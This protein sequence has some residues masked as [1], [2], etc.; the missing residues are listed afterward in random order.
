M[1]FDG[2][3]RSTRR[4]SFR[5]P[6]I[7]S[8]WRAE[9]LRPI[10]RG[11]LADLLSADGDRERPH[12]DLA[13]VDLRA[14]GSDVDMH[15]IQLPSREEKVLAPLSSLEADDV[16]AQHAAQ[17]R[18]PHLVGQG[19]EVG[20][21][22]ERCVGEVEDPRLRD[23]LSQHA[24]N[25]R[26]VVILDQED[27]IVLRLCRERPSER[28]V[29]F[30]IVGPFGLGLFAESRG[31]RD[32]PQVVVDEPQD[33]IGDAVVIGVVLL[34]G[35]I[36][37]SDPLGRPLE[38]A[39]PG[40]DLSITLRDGGGDPG[41]VVSLEYPS[42]HRDQASRP[43]VGDEFAVLPSLEG[44]WTSVRCHDEGGFHRGV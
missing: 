25:E 10:A 21:P 40:R 23:D 32:I 29:R 5:S 33:A 35:D 20:P 38:L 11:G 6:R 39:T 16:G 8:T 26:E 41:G 1:F 36:D 4:R 27:R 9:P 43:S 44:H 28:P 7:F 34:L 18:P 12:L 31:A 42:K 19:P 15:V 2:S 3:I 37:V 22:R 14:M 13:T 24:G 30:D 17:D